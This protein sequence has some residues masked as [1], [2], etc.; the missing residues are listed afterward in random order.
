[1]SDIVKPVIF[2]LQG[3]SMTKCLGTY[4]PVLHV[5]WNRWAE[6][7]QSPSQSLWQLVRDRWA[8]VLRSPPQSLWQLVL[9]QEYTS[10]DELQCGMLYTARY[11][12]LVFLFSC[13]LV[14]GHA[15]EA[16]Q[17][18]HVHSRERLFLRYSF[19]QK[20]LHV[21]MHIHQKAFPTIGHHNIVPNFLPKFL[22]PSQKTGKCEIPKPLFQ[23]LSRLS[24]CPTQN[25]PTAFCKLQ[26]DDQLWEL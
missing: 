17:C 26:R 20:S 13:M 22:K 11:A 5:V 16:P 24:S 10:G 23:T 8:E 2:T 25:E 4:C 12:G 1:M 19:L 6:V 7:L 3:I 18:S 15:T 21:V 9:P 14:C